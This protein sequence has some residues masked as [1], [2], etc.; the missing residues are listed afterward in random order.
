LAAAAAFEHIAAP[1]AALSIAPQSK[2]ADDPSELARSWVEKSNTARP[3][4]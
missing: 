2:T 3:S 1:C 4:P